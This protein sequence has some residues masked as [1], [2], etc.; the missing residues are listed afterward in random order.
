MHLGTVGYLDFT[1]FDDKGM[2]TLQ[3]QLEL[4]A[5]VHIASNQIK[6]HLSLYGC[7]GTGLRF[8]IICEREAST[9]VLLEREVKSKYG[10]SSNSGFL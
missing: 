10:V 8:G 1:S 6:R 7:L 4:Y 2:E 3:E 9:L 5:I